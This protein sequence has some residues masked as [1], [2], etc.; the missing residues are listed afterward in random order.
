M[1]AANHGGRSASAAPATLTLTSEKDDGRTISLALGT[2]LNADL[3]SN[4]TTGFQW[5]VAGA[6]PS[7][8]ELVSTHGV[9]PA[10]AK[11]GGHD[12][13]GAPGRQIFTFRAVRQGTGALRLE[14]RRSWEKETPPAKI[15]TVTVGVE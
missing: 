2:L 12:L 9:A 14:Y 11:P 10:P 15:F 4:P 13:V 6:L 5:S 7:C 8:L 3:A 1:P